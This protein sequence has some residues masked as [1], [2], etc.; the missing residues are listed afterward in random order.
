MMDA[1]SKPDCAP[2]A[3]NEDGWSEWLHPTP[4]FRMQC[5]DCGLVHVMQFAIGGR[6][7]DGPLNEGETDDAVVVFR[8]RREDGAE[9]GR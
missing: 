8:A 9:D 6:D 5:C 4:N 7:G 3:V 2:V 1:D